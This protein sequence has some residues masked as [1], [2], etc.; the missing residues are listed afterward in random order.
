MNVTKELHD[1]IFN[2]HLTYV[3]HLSIDCAVFGF[4]DNQLKIL[5]L[6]SKYLDGWALPGGHIQRNE[7]IDIAAQRILKERTGLDKIFLKQYQTFGDPDR[8]KT[9]SSQ[10]FLNAVQLPIPP[11]NW[12]MERIVSIGYYAL[13]EFS[14]ATPTPDLFTE[15][16]DWWDIHQLPALIFDHDHMVDL[17]LQTL[18]AQLHYQPIG[19][20]LLSDKFTMPELQKLYE[21]ILDKPLDRRNF[22]KKIMGLGILEKLEERKSVGPHKSPYYYRFHEKNYENALTAGLAFG[23]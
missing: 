13:V 1:F 14:K 2:G 16:C 17:A 18:Q 9:Q 4:H 8:L 21:T 15:E 5:L 23:F 12:L 11:N 19:Y 3:P 7:H 20:N 6:R 22:Q 10:Y